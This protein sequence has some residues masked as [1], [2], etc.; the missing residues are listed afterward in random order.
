MTNLKN[1]L[2]I[3]IFIIS[4]SFFSCK[5]DDSEKV[6]PSSSNAY[7][8]KWMYEQ[9]NE[10]Y[11]WG[12]PVSASPDSDIDPY[13]YFDAFLNRQY[14]RFSWCTD[15]FA[16]ILDWT[17]GISTDIGFHYFAV[18]DKQNMAPF[19]LVAYTKPGTD[20]DKAGIVRG[21]IITSV[22]GVKVT[23]ENYGSLLKSSS[24][25]NYVLQIKGKTESVNINAMVNYAENPVYYSN[26][27]TEGTYKIGYLVYNSF[28]PDRGN[29]SKEYDVLLMNKMKEFYDA[30]IT[31]L[32][33][34]LRYNGGGLVKCA[35][36]LAS[37]IVKNR[38]TK[39]LF[40]RNEFGINK[41]NEIK[42]WSKAKQDEW[43]YDY[44]LDKYESGLTGFTSAIP[45]LGDKIDK[46]YILTGKYTASS[47]ELVINSLKPHM[48]VVLIG[49]KTYGKNVASISLYE[50][51][52]DNNKWGLQ[53]IVLKMYNSEDKSDYAE[54][55][56]P[57]KYIN[58]FDSDLKPL[59]DKDEVL[60]SAAISDITGKSNNSQLRSSNISNAKVISSVNFKKG[61]LDMFID[62][63]FYK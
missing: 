51:K 4:I 44:Y 30:G 50:E 25:G 9:M 19:Y 14:D 15:D 24:N 35:Q 8:N 46:V 56:D 21:D 41:T 23:S 5:D 17:N 58:E 34:D 10:W 36:N 16:T 42:K 27:Y 61:G 26:I 22:N 28:T 6:S 31:D 49:Q 18:L 11:L 48:S 54:G 40:A 39:V 1:C 59:G 60:L 33:L 29:N 13:K 20:A 38:D 47:S 53:P 52:N 7:I 2:Y 62:R 3:S 57:D 32:V 45:R 43:L 37:A 63:S 12:I 55:F